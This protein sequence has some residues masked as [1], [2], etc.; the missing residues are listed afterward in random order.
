MAIYLRL[1]S[2]LQS[3]RFTLFM[4]FLC[5]IVLALTTGLY[6]Y[7]IG[8]VIKFLFSGGTD[9]IPSNNIFGI[10]IPE[11]ITSNRS[12]MLFI[13]PVLI[14]VTAF[15]KGGAYFGQFYLM[16]DVGQRVIKDIRNK[17][18]IHLLRLSPG[19]YNNRSH[20][21]IVSR[22]TNDVTQLEYAVTYA[23]A[24]LI[25]DSLQII[26][27]I[28][29][30]VYLDW[31][32]ALISFVGVPISLFPII[33]FGKKLTKVSSDSQQSVGYITALISEVIRNINIVQSFN[34][35][36]YEENRFRLK[37]NDY[38]KT[39][40][41]SFWLRALTSPIMEFLGALALACTIWYAA[42]RVNNGTL[43]PAYFLSFFAAVMMLYQPLKN[44]GRVNNFIRPGI[45][46]AE[47]IF[48]FLDTELEIKEQ[49]NACKLNNFTGKVCLENIT[50]SY[51]KSIEVL[52]NV[53][54]TIEN[55]E[56][57]ALAGPSGSGKSTIA[58][59]LLRF[60]DPDKGQITFDNANITSCTL[61]SLREQIGYV[62]Q[63]SILFNDTVSANIAY[64]LLNISQQK[65]EEAAKAANAHEFILAL[66]NGYNTVIG[67]SGIKLSGGQR[68]RLAIA[69]AILKNP[70]LLIL[71]EATSS[72]DMESEN[73][74][75][76]ALERLTKNRTTLVIAHR[77]N[78][79]K[80]ADKII[81]LK[82][83]T[84][85]SEGSHT[86][87]IE[88]CDIYKRYYELGGGNQPTG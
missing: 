33:K 28:G 17:M 83:G 21:T 32:L 59:L 39:I 64:G 9:V 71:D 23:I 57:T 74:V 1:L 82:K 18:Y 30:A 8:P 37:N 50:F 86:E 34:A 31:K 22:F 67:E 75:Q 60:A 51:E 46:A 44:L 80:S 49:D 81:V 25:R 88:K 14:A 12:L 65:I 61:K 26:V 55:G 79:L 35:E 5:M 2:L 29:V 66:K 85:I 62:S 20:G 54:L 53:N 42:D 36:K 58:F 24:T 10:S 15:I 48:E 68:Q 56:K 76:Q 3:V 27:L 73:L 69:R 11:S 38:Y 13:L 7:L 40:M 87:L 16:G 4:A 78:T 52:K 63:D 43:E 41:K 84:V 6:A 47:R 70:P 72:L 77:L 19:Y 45:A